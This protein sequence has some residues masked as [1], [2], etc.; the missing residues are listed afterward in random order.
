M[1]R[2]F[3]LKKGPRRSVD[4]AQLIKMKLR[5]IRA[6]VWFRALPRIDRVL[7]DLTIKVAHS[8]RST[9]LASSILSVAKKL[10]GLFESKL[11]RAIR[12]IGLSLTTKLSLIAQNW[13][14]KTAE[15]W[16]S[17]LNF[18]RYLAVMKLN[19]RIVS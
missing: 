16:D 7:I 18:A 9:T 2:D 19:C 12:D 10:E 14:N 3:S 6:G 13:G 8:I 17:D 11:T 4:R 15:A 1:M 5:A